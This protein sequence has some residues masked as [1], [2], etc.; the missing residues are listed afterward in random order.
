MPEKLAHRYDGGCTMCR[1]RAGSV[2]DLCLICAGTVP[3]MKMF[4]FRLN[5]ILE[6]GSPVRKCEYYFV[7]VVC[8]FARYRFELVSLEGIL[9]SM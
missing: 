3:K 5:N 7:G 8:G 6:D 1:G 2:P 9:L 4:C